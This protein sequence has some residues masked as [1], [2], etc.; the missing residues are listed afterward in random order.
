MQP[1]IDNRK[2][3]R[4]PVLKKNHH[5]HFERFVNFTGDLGELRARVVALAQ[6]DGEKEVGYIAF[7]INIAPLEVDF[8]SPIV[9]DLFAH[10]LK[11]EVNRFPFF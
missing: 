10:Q 4:I 7:S 8:D 9:T 11:Q 6:L 2:C 3:E 1:A 5:R